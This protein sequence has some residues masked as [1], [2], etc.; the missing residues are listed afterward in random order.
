[1]KILVKALIWQIF[2]NLLTLRATKCR[3]RMHMTHGIHIAKISS[4]P[5][6]IESHL[7]LPYYF[8]L[9]LGEFGIVYKGYII[10]GQVVTEIVAVKTL[11][12]K[13]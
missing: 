6:P 2:R 12:G 4:L 7:S 10:K 3:L 8:F 13:F 1:M 9:F 5:T 11:K